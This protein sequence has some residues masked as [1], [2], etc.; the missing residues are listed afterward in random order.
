MENNL[1]CQNS[2]QELIGFDWSMKAVIG[3]SSLAT[4]QQPLVGVDFYLGEPGKSVNDLK[5]DTSTDSFSIEMNQNE[6]KN[7]ISVLEKAVGNC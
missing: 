2:I 6:L 5:P 7:L 3:S 1:S 4:L